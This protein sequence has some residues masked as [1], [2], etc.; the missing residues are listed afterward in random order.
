MTDLCFIKPLD[1]LFLRSNKLFGDPGSFG[2]SLVMPR[3]SVVAGALRSA[4]IAAKDYDFGK[5]SRGEIIG[6]TELGTPAK[7]GTLIL[8]GL[9]LARRIPDNSS[10]KYERLFPIPRDLFVNLDLDGEED[11]HRIVP[12]SISKKVM[13]SCTFEQLP[14]LSQRQRSKS[15]RVSYYLTTS[16]WNA[17]LQCEQVKKND[18]VC[19]ETLWKLENRIGIGLSQSTRSAEP[20]HLFTSQAVSFSSRESDSSN[21]IDIG[22]IAEV[23]GATLPKSMMVKFGGDGR[24]ASVTRLTEKEVVPINDSVLDAIER[25]KQCRIILTSPGLFREGWALEGVSKRNGSF[26]FHLN[27]VSGTLDCAAVPRAETISGFDIA[28]GS[29]KPAERV[30]PSGSVYW[31]SSMR[32]TRESLTTLGEY[33]LWSSVRTNSTRRTEGYNRFYFAMY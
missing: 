26:R 31:L 28:G 25:T 24:G 32:F 11:I 5:F 23:S 17:H 13:S 4:L 1:V 9:Y 21:P 12:K 20:G 27:G 6:D 29:P 19:A 33:G 15:R 16:G 30:A 22:F 7:P 3:P 2:E 18:I 14:I 8:T 10:A